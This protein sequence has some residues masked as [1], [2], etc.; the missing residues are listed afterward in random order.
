M[1][2]SDQF[3]GAKI[4]SNTNLLGGITG[5][6]KGSS[7]FSRFFSSSRRG[8]LNDNTYNAVSILSVEVGILIKIA[9][10]LVF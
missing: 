6:L 7:I 1:L 8:S 2:S 10:T 5:G 4:C 3:I 9:N